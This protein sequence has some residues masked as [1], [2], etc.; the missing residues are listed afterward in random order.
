MSILAL[1]DYTPSD[2][3][4]AERILLI[5]GASDGI[6]AALAKRCAQ[7]G[8][9]VILNGRD[10]RKLEAVYDSIVA[11]GGP[12][13]AMLPLDFKRAKLDQYAELANV[14]E[15]EFGRLDGLAHIAGILG[16]M[17]PIAHYAPMAWHDVIHVNLNAVFLLTQACI[18]LLLKSEDA[19]AVFASSSVGRK[20]RAH[21]GAYAVSK[22][23]VEGLMQ[24]VA[25][26]H[27]RE[28][29]GIRSNSV[30]PGATRTDMRA[31]AYPAE[32]K[33]VLLTP[34]QVLAPFIYCLGP[35]SKGTSGKTFDAQ[36]K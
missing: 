24:I 16:D 8:A 23:G 31:S 25:D 19:T 4:L 28:K 29:G 11:D 2:N 15:N 35:D 10:T 34:E 12:K 7:L 33:S 26:E 32:D 27:D 18:P 21:W 22:F 13:P 17:S 9:T 5:T 14:V 20:G 6:G 30:N 1:P 36:P 3:V